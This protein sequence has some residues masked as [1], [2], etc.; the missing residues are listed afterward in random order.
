M[1]TRNTA[2]LTALTLTTTADACVVVATAG[3]RTWT[4]RFIGD[5]RRERAGYFVRQVKAVR[6]RADHVAL[7]FAEEQ[8]PV[9][10]VRV[11]YRF[12]VE[13]SVVQVET[14]RGS[15]ERQVFGLSRPGGGRVEVTR[16]QLLQG[17][18]DGRL[19]CLF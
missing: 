12:V 13:G 19:V 6:E 3:T 2:P 18:R 7:L 17:Q 15:G 4:R 16:P 1:T 14:S 8:R 10:Y 5:D 11:G 9:E